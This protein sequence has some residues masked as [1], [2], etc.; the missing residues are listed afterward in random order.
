MVPKLAVIGGGK[1]G[2]MHLRA[3]TQL[4]SEGKAELV[5]LADVNADVLKARADEF[6]VRTYSNHIE[7]IEKEKPDG[8]GIVTPD[9]LHK[10][11]S[12]DCLERGVHVLVE[13]PLDTTI[14]GCRAMDETARKNG[15]LM[16]V[17]FHKRYDPY[18][19]EMEKSVRKGNIG[20]VLYGYAWMEDRIEVPRDWFPHW[21]P[22]SSPGW[23]LGVH[24]FDLIYW[25]IKSWPKRVFASGCKDKLKS[26]GI[27]AYDSIS[28]S[29][30]F[31]NGAHFAVQNS[32]I[33]P[34]GFE[35]VVNQGIR[36][37]G[38]EGIIEIDSQDRGG[39]A[40]YSKDGM[41]TY[42]LG[43][44][45]ETKNK[46]GETVFSGYGIESI[47]DFAYNLDYL[48]NGGKLEDLE[49]T[50]AGARD[51]LAATSI[52]VAAHESLATGKA[53]EIEPA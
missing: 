20:N 8:V 37:V 13:K 40:C 4:Q 2:V 6:G 53:I 35:A 7:M 46:K 36:V 34:D 30:V 21:A 10:Q 45:A 41:M 29:V 27:D 9:F 33:L 42:N 1:F 12:I 17:D 50:Y 14:E 48:I 49:G 19:K 44:F 16:Q 43:F 52:G 25:T 23:F 47:Q 39:R 3:F 24:F 22:K 11:L 51:G 32:W 5:G 15:L 38:S 26:L 31:E 28:T 18:H